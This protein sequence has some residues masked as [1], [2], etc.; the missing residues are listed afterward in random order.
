MNA[1]LLYIIGNTFY[2]NIN[3]SIPDSSFSDENDII[4]PALVY[5]R[6]PVDLANASSIFNTVHSGLKQKDSNIHPV[7]VSFIPAY[8]PQNTRLYHARSDRN[9]PDMFEWIA[10]NY[11]FSY[12]FSG[13]KRRVEE[14]EFSRNDRG[15]LF[16]FRTKRPLNKVIF[17]DGASAAKSAPFMDQ[18]MILSKQE[19]ISE[20]VDERLAAEKICNWGKSFGL[21]GFIR[22]EVGYEMVLCDFHENVEVISNISLAAAN[23]LIKFPA[24][25]LK[26]VSG[27][28]MPHQTP[29]VPLPPNYNSLSYNRSLLLN[30]LQA[31]S[32]FEWVRSGSYQD[33]GEERIFLDFAN[34]ITPLNK[35][36]INPD[37]Y[38]RNISYIAQNL[39]EA[40]IEDLET[41]YKTPTD[42]FYKTNWPVVT[43]LITLKFSPMLVNLN[44]SL[45]HKDSKSVSDNIQ[46]L[47]YNFIRRYISED[48]NYTEQNMEAAYKTCVLDYVWYTYPLQGSDYLIYSS[49]FKVHSVIIRLIFDLFDVSRELTYQIYVNDIHR[50]FDWKTFQ[51]R[52]GNLMKLL[53]WS[54]FYQ[55]SQKCGS[56]EFCYTPTWGPS[57]FGWGPQRNPE[58]FDHDGQT[59]RIRH[60]LKC[61]NYKDIMT[62]IPSLN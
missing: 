1:V 46:L 32:G 56:D 57:P 9:I 14:Q 5:D 24:E 49:I 59:Y 60:E 43:N 20:P 19:N 7:G 55:C 18:Q 44:S 62:D 38:I 2:A 45:Y 53:N 8:I 54:D 3:I 15:F 17:L 52:I 6:F 25:E 30:H 23:D 39:K 4:D 16:T 26:Y 28:H 41:I 40:I 21:Q 37:S 22:L 11:E 36:F 58:L 13:F 27:P 50:K 35:T 34:M 29:K 33:P 61:M 47:T 42:P 10:F 12:S 51:I 31:V 48:V